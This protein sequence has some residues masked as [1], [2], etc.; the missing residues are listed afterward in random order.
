[1]HSILHTQEHRRVHFR[2]QFL[3]T[4]MQQLS[5]LDAF[6]L[7]FELPNVPMH[8]AGLSIYDPSTA[9]GGAVRHKQI[10][11]HTAS[12]VQRVPSLARRLQEVP[13]GLDHPYWV[14]DGHFDPEFHVRHLALP[15]PGD[16]RQLCIMVGRLHSRALDRS[17]PLWE[18]YVIEGLD[19]VEGYPK[20]SFA[21]LTKMHHAAVDGATGMEIEAAIHDLTPRLPAPNE[22]DM[23]TTEKPPGNLELILRSQLNN[24]RKPMRILSVA[25]NT[26]PGFAKAY[27][28]LRTGKLESAG[29]VPRTRFNKVVSPHRVFEGVSLRLDEFKAIKD[30]VSGATVNDVALTVVGGALRK[31]LESKEELPETSLVAMAPVNVRNDS[32]K[33]GGGNVISA[34]AVSVRSDI[35][36]PLERLKAVHNCTVNA[37][38]LNN[39]V[40]AKTMTDYSQFIPSTLTARAARVVSSLGL[41]NQT[42]PLYNC[43]I[44]NVPG[45]QVPLY[46]TGARKLSGFSPGPIF[47]GIGLIHV[48]FSYCGEITISIT[49]CRDMMPDPQF[50][51]ECI[52]RSFQELRRDVLDVGGKSRPGAEGKSK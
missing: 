28:K 13:L 1:M 31:Y 19:N 9:P 37:K 23:P 15:K 10:I 35:D 45:A 49:A 11:E 22:Q 6:F 38:E 51:R 46:N 7:Y 16:W 18:L 39:A 27:L 36:N 12:R 50:Y 21:I 4:H 48:V 14:L 29:V 52:E 8:V 33:G 34:M 17:R 3:A 47:D 44:T 30:R 32:E 42:K 41:M 40:G 2:N 5:G 26:V 20:G 24:V 25:R 43:V